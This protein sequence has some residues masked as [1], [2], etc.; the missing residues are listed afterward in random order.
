MT[1]LIE[2]KMPK[3]SVSYTDFLGNL[4]FSQNTKDSLKVVPTKM[5]SLKEKDLADL[6]QLESIFEN[7]TYFYLLDTVQ[8]VVD[9]PISRSSITDGNRLIIEFKSMLNKDTILKPTFIFFSKFENTC[10]IGKKVDTVNTQ[11][12]AQNLRLVQIIDSEF[13]DLQESVLRAIQD[14]SLSIYDYKGSLV[15]SNIFLKKEEIINLDF[16]LK[17]K[18]LYFIRNNNFDKLPPLKYFHF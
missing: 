1:K 2:K 17:S 16:Y 14:V 18:G 4:Y 6:D 12:C 3:K 10:Y 5:V 7:I 13:I 15:R 11:I 8:V 9:I